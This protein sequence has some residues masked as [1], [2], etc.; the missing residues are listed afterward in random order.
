[1]NTGLDREREVHRKKQKEIQKTEV[2]INTTAKF[3]PKV[4]GVE[5]HISGEPQNLRI[6]E[7]RDAI[8]GIW[9]SSTE[10]ILGPGM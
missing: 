1:M 6:G 2:N 10:R 7:H 9:Q 8:N 4:T 5:K 3:F